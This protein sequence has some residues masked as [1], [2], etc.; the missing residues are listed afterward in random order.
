M[1]RIEALEERVRLLEGSVEAMASVVNK[2][3]GD[4]YDPEVVEKLDKLACYGEEE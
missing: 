1:G 2:I 3:L 4:F